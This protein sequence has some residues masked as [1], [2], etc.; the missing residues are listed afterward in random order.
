MKE[1][2]LYLLTYDIADD[3]RLRRVASVAEKYGV[4]LQYSVFLIRASGARLQ[5][6]VDELQKIICEREDD[7]RI[8]PLPANPSWEWHGVA[9]WPEG[10]SLSGTWPDLVDKEEN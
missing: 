1:S 8:Y 2:A 3:A 9:L 4:R 5:R 6:L 10:I 7:V